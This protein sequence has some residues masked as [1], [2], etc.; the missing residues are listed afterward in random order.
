MDS[1][2]SQREKTS[3]DYV[4][5]HTTLACVKRLLGCVWYDRILRSCLNFRLL[6]DCVACCPQFAGF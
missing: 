6:E 3:G 1:S 4:V 2:P 5:R